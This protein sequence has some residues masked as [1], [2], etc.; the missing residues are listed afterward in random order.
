MKQRLQEFALIEEIDRLRQ[1][2][3]QPAFQ[4]TA[5]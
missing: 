4:Y 1:Q 5:D 3:G 2:F